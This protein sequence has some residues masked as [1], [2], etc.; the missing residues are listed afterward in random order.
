MKTFVLVALALFAL[1]PSASA[2][3]HP[4]WM[5]SDL[6]ATTIG[7]VD[8]QNSLTHTVT[9][10][11]KSGSI[12]DEEWFGL[13]DRVVDAGLYRLCFVG[14][15]VWTGEAL[16]D[17][18]LYRFT[19]GGAHRPMSEVIANLRTNGIAIGSGPTPEWLNSL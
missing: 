8:L 6:S 4:F 5:T 15:L 9:I 10:V 13:T 19:D 16:S 18:W 1:A 11:V 3:W 2:E 7:Y 14:R 12:S 17:V